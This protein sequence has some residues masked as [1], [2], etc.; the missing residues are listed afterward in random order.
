MDKPMVPDA[1]VVPGPPELPYSLRSR[2][3]SISIFWTLFII[4]T[5]VQP[6]VLY[7]TLWYCT[8]LSHN[9][10]FTIST[11][12]LGGV[13]VVEYFYRFY[14]LFKKGSKVRPLNARRS[15]LDFFQ[16][17]FTIV[18]LILAVELIIGTVQEEPYIRLLAMPLP[19]VMFYFGLVHLTLDLLRAL[20]Y[21]APFRISSTPKGYV[22][23]TALYVL[24]ED[25]VAVD[26]GGGQVYRRAIRDRYLSSPYFRQMLFEMNC[27]WGGGSVVFAAVI[28]ALVFTTPR[29]VAYTL[30]WSLP[31]VWAG[32]WVLI[33]IPWVQAD[34]RKEKAA[35]GK[36]SLH[37]IPYTDDITCPTPQTR[38][39][40]VSGRLMSSLP[41]QKPVKPDRIDDNNVASGYDSETV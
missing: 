25:V 21:Q 10:V 30:G 26:G 31:F 39:I 4:D 3:R 5:L 35:W 32:T 24:I 40:S 17:N 22:M 20:G 36:Y 37:G 34:L 6:L 27:F 8:N 11:A 38:F 14:N 7:F 12:A 16:V 33:T 19:T 29:D 28:T 13:A 2:K 41:F 18:W 15:W 1:P 23:P 9:L